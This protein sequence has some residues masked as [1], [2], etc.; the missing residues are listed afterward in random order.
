MAL[1]SRSPQARLRLSRAV[2]RLA[3]MAAGNR[4]AVTLS[5]L[6]LAYPESDQRW[7]EDIATRCFEQLGRLLGE[8]LLLDRDEALPS[9]EIEGWEHLE[10]VAGT[11]KGYLLVSAHFGNWEL[12]AQLQAI[13][14]YPI[15][16]I[17]RPSDNRLL[18]TELTRVR[19]M[20]GNRVIYKRQAVRE[21]VKVLKSG[22]C[23]GIIIDQN[24]REA[25]P[26]FVPFFGVLAA[27]TRT[28]GTMSLRLGVPFITSF[29]FPRPDGSYRI[30]YDEP[31]FPSTIEGDDPAREITARATALIEAAVRK[32]PEAWFWMHQRWRTRPPEGE[33]TVDG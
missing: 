17:A 25:D 10:R 3:W 21:I 2:G 27:T 14:G 30:V 16:L 13:K 1:A 9:A 23:A 31:V 26:H 32:Q 11:G 5:N 15:S 19:Q 29:A 18:D 7:R 20:R 28:L 6:A 8:I 24:Y 33:L 12:L 22:G 4:R